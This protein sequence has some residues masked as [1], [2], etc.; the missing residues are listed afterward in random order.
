MLDIKVAKSVTNTE[1]RISS[2]TVIIYDQY[3]LPAVENM[4]HQQIEFEDTLL[5]L[6]KGEEQGEESSNFFIAMQVIDTPNA[7][8]K[9][10]LIKK[11]SSSKI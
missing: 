2:L 11:K 10:V 6:K 1:E 8:G 9:Q 3:Q 4:L 7:S 5:L